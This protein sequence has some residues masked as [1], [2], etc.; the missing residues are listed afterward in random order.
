M[1][2]IIL[3]F[4]MDI[5]DLLLKRNGFGL[6]NLKMEKFEK[7]EN[8]MYKGL[9]DYVIDYVFIKKKDKYILLY[10]YFDEIIIE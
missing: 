9:E 6:L 3:L 8:I 1:L 5:V 4:C 2:K 10:N 7:H